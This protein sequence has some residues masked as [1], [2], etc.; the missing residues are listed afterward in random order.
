MTKR[1]LRRYWKL[2]D[3]QRERPLT[4]DEHDELRGLGH[5]ADEHNKANQ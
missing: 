3:L 4:D 1:D 5:Q 2:L